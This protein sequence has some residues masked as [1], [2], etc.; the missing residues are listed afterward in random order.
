MNKIKAA[1]IDQTKEAK[2]KPVEGLVY[3]SGSFQSGSFEENVRLGDLRKPPSLSSPPLQ[4]GEVMGNAAGARKPRMRCKDPAMLHVRHDQPVGLDR[5]KANPELAQGGDMQLDFQHKKTKVTAAESF[6]PANRGILSST[7]LNRGILSSTGLNKLTKFTDKEVALKP[8]P[9]KFTTADTYYLKMKKSLNTR[10]ADIK[11][12][13]KDSIQHDE[14]IFNPIIPS[15][16][17]TKFPDR[18]VAPEKDYAMHDQ[19]AEKSRADIQRLNIKK[20]DLVERRETVRA[21][22]LGEHYRGITSTENISNRVTRLPNEEAPEASQVKRMFSSDSLTS[23]TQQKEDVTWEQRMDLACEKGTLVQL[24]NLDPSYASGEIEDIVRTYLNVRCT[25]KVL[26]QSTF[27]SPHNGQA[28]L[29]FKT[30]AQAEMVISELGS[31]C[32]MLPNGRPLI[33]QRGVPRVLRDKSATM[34]GHL[35]VNRMNKNREWAKALSTSH[36]A[37]PN[38]IEYELALD[39]ILMQKRSEKFWRTLYEVI[40]KELNGRRL[41][42]FS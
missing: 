8:V 24:Q 16:R 17:S 4:G 21:K 32:L 12:P 6:Q 14:G 13:K 38:T 39:W 11:E 40:I 2:L 27:S 18:E 19:L 28:L 42:V 31:R 25:A 10:C 9:K 37:Q 1:T 34:I 23:E 35:M 20:P 5:I 22:D 26:E 7:N 33:A 41:S 30:E 36:C 15:K 29:I 3:H